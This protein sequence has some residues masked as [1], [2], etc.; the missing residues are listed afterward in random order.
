MLASLDTH[1]RVFLSRA[2]KHARWTGLIDSIQV[3]SKQ[4]KQALHNRTY[5]M[6]KETT[7]HNCGL[8]ELELRV[9]TCLKS[10]E[11][12]ETLPSRI[13]RR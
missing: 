3:G 8:T 4:V 5:S 13:T 7:T 9:A 2:K 6:H 11:R 1:V 10:E 12:Q